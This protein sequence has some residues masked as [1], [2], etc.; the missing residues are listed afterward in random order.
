MSKNENKT[1]I[2]TK[3]EPPFDKTKTYNDYAKIVTSIN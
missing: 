1:N 2:V 3:T